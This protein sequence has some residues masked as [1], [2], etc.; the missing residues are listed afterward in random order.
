MV[1][2]LA[3]NY[4][5][6]VNLK[7]HG[8]YTPLH[9]A[10][11]FGRQEVFDLLVKAYK[12]DPRIRDNHGKTPRQYMMTQEQS[13]GL[14]LS[15]DTFRQLKDRRRNRREASEKNP[16][17]LRF[18]S[19][20]VKVKKTTEAFNSYFGSE[21]KHSWGS[22]GGADGLDKIDSQKMPP[23]KFGPIK[24]RKSKRSADF[25]RVK[26]A[27]TTPTETSPIKEDAELSDSEFG[28]DSAQ[29]GSGVS[30]T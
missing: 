24:K 20:S 5:V 9:L 28:F 30:P 7:T 10:C 8:G 23:P 29:W 25:G 11:Q 2:L 3:G 17:I 1:K 6:D 19:L 15:S 26:S 4:H 12:A 18:G 14:S 13:T 22:S 27:P 21:R 16:S